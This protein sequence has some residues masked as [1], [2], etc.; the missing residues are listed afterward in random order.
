MSI[1]KGVLHLYSETGT[2]GGYW[3]IQ[4]ER[5]IEIVDDYERWDYKG[6]HCLKN[7]DR[8]K[9][10]SPEGTIYWEGE[11][12]LKP[13]PVFTENV[14]VQD[15]S[16]DTCLGLWIHADQTGIDRQEWALPFLKNYK[17]ILLRES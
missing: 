2:E 3:A 10:F 16:S 6:L 14:G 8:L 5:H 4:D 7:G 9:I 1:I 15:E 13:Y 12:N 17:A 11:I